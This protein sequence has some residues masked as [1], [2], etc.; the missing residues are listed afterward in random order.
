MK[1]S[2]GKQINVW[3]D[4]CHTPQFNFYKNF[5]IHLAN[6]GYL[7]YVT[8]LN[9]G[10]TP[11][12]VKKEL[13]SFTNVKVSVIGRH[14]LV[15]CSAII[16]ANL[17]RVIKLFL[18]S[19]NKHIDISY[20]NAFFNS[21]IGKI[22]KFKSF[23][24]D[25]DPQT[26]DFKLKTLFSDKNHYCLYEL[27]STYKLP[28]NAILLRVLKE[29]AYLAPNVFTPN[30]MALNKY[31]IKPKEYFFLREVSV[32]TIN[33][34][35]QAVGAI[36]NVASLIPQDKKVLF[37]LEDKSK[38]EL[39]PPSW[40]LLEE[41]IEDIHSLIYYSCG[42]IS[43]GDSMAREAALLG[44]PSYYLGIRY[45]MPANIAASKFGSLYNSQTMAFKSWI[46]QFKESSIN[47]EEEQEA[48]RDRINHSFIDINEYMYSLMNS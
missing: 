47:F 21:F 29:W 5:I 40:I 20:S 16:E 11:T 4:I 25:D 9:R 18:W 23:N 31:N 22:N 3:I 43:S 1:E 34:A 41:P 33:Y 37:S 24:F 27:P 15:K 30:I 10:K 45:A 12:I 7:V 39:Y 13:L 14:R 2:V 46:E 26:Y 17:F 38:K 42:L 48:I 28:S 32:G 19:L 36:I 6:E 8:V 44:V 35:G